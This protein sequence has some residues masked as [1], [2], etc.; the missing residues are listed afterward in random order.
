MR[1][2]ILD[3]IPLLALL[4]NAGYAFYLLGAVRECRRQIDKLEVRRD[5]WKKRALDAESA[6]SSLRYA[7]KECKKQ[8]R[9][10]KAKAAE[11][12]EQLA[13]ARD[14]AALDAET[15]RHYVLE[16]NTAWAEVERLQDL[17][18]EVAPHYCT[19]RDPGVFFAPDCFIHR[20]EDDARDDHLI[21]DPD[22][23]AHNPLE[24]PR[25]PRLPAVR[26]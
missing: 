21:L 23:R 24:T 11:L 3:L 18:L 4:Y 12:T 5:K 1:E 20:S 6:V 7:L 8:L 16:R 22:R 2:R 14:K 15:A 25:V 26:R 9:K 13:R 17:L 10:L 19:C